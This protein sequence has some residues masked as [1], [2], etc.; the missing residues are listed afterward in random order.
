M[1]ARFW[2]PSSVSRK[3]GWK[4]RSRQL[5]GGIAALGS[6]AKPSSDHE[7]KHHEEVVLQCQDEALAEPAKAHH[8][9]AGNGSD[10]RVHGAEYPGAAEA[11]LHQWPRSHDRLEPFEIDDDIGK[12]RHRGSLQS[13]VPSHQPESCTQ[14]LV[15]GAWC[16]LM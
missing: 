4:A 16:L 1:L 14:C 9:L 11:N 5:L 8:L 2:E 6:H 7:M 13:P 12:L 15:P 10:R 3:A